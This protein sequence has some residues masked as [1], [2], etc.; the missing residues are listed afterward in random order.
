MLGLVGRG[1]K[2]ERPDARDRHVPHVLYKLPKSLEGGPLGLLLTRHGNNHPANHP[3]Q[4]R[5]QRLGPMSS[6]YYERRVNRFDS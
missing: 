1:D 6:S 2:C 3:A 5:C 4:V